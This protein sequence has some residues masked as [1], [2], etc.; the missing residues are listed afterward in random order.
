MNSFRGFI[1]CLG[2]TFALPWIF[3]IVVP[4][5]ATSN[6][7]VVEFEVEGEK[8]TYPP[9]RVGAVRGAEVYARNGCAYCHTQMVRP[10][11][12]GTDMWRPG[13][14]GRGG[15]ESTLRS[16]IPQD[17]LGEK[18]AYLGALRHGPD[19]SNV[20]WRITD[21]KWHYEHLY[22]PRS[23]KPTTIMPSYRNLFEKRR[24]IGQLSADAI[25][26]F[27]KNGETWEVVPSNDAKS[28]VD[29]LMSLKKDFLVPD[30][31]AATK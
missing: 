10:T 5:K 14:A 2:A 23:I 15:E 29:Y 22:D 18:Y 3:L 6:L 9:A 16:T 4:F 21:R 7:D 11:Y 1:L 25:E 24:V 13:W 30:S 20:G 8:V 31:L 26:T 19:L 28:L 12:A 17:Y 27:E